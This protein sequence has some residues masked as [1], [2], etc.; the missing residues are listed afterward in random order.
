M[1][2]EGIGNINAIKQKIEEDKLSKDNI[3]DDE[4]NPYHKII[5]NNTGK[6]NIITS[7]MEQWSILSNKVNCMYSMT[8]MQKKL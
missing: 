8:E 7:Q 1:E 6:E 4:I 5:I 2:S 3:D